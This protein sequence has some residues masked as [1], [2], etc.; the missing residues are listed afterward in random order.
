MSTITKERKI[1]KTE[2]RNAIHL[3]RTELNPDIHY[4]KTQVTYDDGTREPRIALLRDFKRPVYVTKPS[5]RDHLDKKEFEEIGKLDVMMSTESD[6]EVSYANLLGNPYLASN[7]KRLNESPYVYGKNLKASNHIKLKSLEANDFI[8][9]PYTVAGL[10]LETNTRNDIP[11]LPYGDIITGTIGRILPNGRYETYTVIDTRWLESGQLTIDTIN[12]EFEARLEKFK[13]KVTRK[14]VFFNDQIDLIKALFRIAN[15]W[16]PD[17]LTI[18]NMMFDIHDTI[19]RILNRH[20]VDPKE[21]F[22]DPKLPHALRRFEFIPGMDKKVTQSGES[23][24]VAP[25][26][27]WHKVYATSKYQ[28]IDSMCTYRTL[29]IHE[30]LLPKY[31]LDFVLAH[32]LGSS[33]LK[34]EGTDQMSGMEWHRHMQT[35]QKPVYVVYGIADVLEMLELEVKNKDLQNEVPTYAGITD[36]NDFKGSEA[37]AYGSLYVY[38]KSKGY[39]LGTGARMDKVHKQYAEDEDFDNSEAYRYE[40]LGIRDWIQTLPQG[41]VMMMG[42]NIFDD[43]RNFRSNA[44]GNNKDSDAI[45]S[46]PKGIMTLNVSKATCRDEIIAIG[47]IPVYTFKAM[48]LAIIPGNAN[49]IEYCEEMHG[50][51]GMDDITRRLRQGVYDHYF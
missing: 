26:D 3:P 4:V 15:D 1:V 30:G 40:T 8:Q 17:F 51:R 25:S 19:L 37:K 49:T 22:C 35:R 43:F 21:I 13:G 50:L 16:A 2:V 10:D 29:R 39:I 6:V 45:S 32:D 46:Y 36:F 34:V 5:Y 23:S 9:T 12:K 38:G 20:K 11:G 14:F 47:D 44:R 27:Q 28:I 24:S 7:P 33:K 48:N 18:W 42:L 41:N 31:N